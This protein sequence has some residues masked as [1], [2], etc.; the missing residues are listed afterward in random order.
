IKSLSGKAFRGIIRLY[1]NG[2]FKAI[3]SGTLVTAILQSSSAV[4]LMVLAFVGAGV[5]NIENAIGVIMGSNI[6]TTFTAWIVATLGFK[7]KIEGFALPF[8]GIGGIGLIFF[9]NSNRLLYISRLLMGFGFLFL[10]LDYMKGSVESFPQRFDLSGVPDYG[11]WFYLAIGTIFTGLMQASAASIA[12]VLTVL[13]SH[14]ITFE[15]GVAMVIAANV[16]TTITLLLGS[17]GGAQSKKSQLQ[18][19]DLQCGHRHCRFSG[20][21]LSAVVYPSI[22]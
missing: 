5:M 9:R 18:P 1:T 16:G 3:G 21:S 14:L 17:M 4:S 7:I 8:V 2:R 20:A 22:L 12:I 6:G 19:P 11:L 15:I 13:N 10:G